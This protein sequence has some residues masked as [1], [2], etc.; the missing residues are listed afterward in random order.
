MPPAT[1]AGLIEA[2]K[3]VGFPVVVA[4][5]L[6]WIGKE[7]IETASARFDRQQEFITQTLSVQLEKSTTVMAAVN[8]TMKR[9]ADEQE[10][11]R[12]LMR[13][14]REEKP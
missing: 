3:Q 4:G 6:I 5:V 9:L 12:A 2:V 1:Q 14:I 13:E 8:E 11:T 7:Q 10:D